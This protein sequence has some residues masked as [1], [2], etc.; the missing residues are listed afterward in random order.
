MVYLYLFY[1]FFMKNI[2]LLGNGGREHALANALSRS[3]QSIALF[4]FFSAKNPGIQELCA[5]VYIEKEKN[6]GA[7]S[8]FQSLKTFAEKN[9]IDFAVLGP[10]DPIGAGCADAL[11]E[12]GVPSFGPT[13][14]PAQLES[15]KGFTRSLL[16][17]YGIEGNPEFKRFSASEKESLAEYLTNLSYPFVIKDD[18]I[19]GGKGV[20]VHSDHFQTVEEGIEI[21]ERIL[22]KSSALVIEEKL[23]GPEFSLICIADGYTLIP[24]PLVA[25]HKRAYEG[26]TGPNT[27]GM[28]TISFADHLLPFVDESDKNK[29]LSIT[30]KVMEA[31]RE[32]TGKRFCGVL[33]GGFMKT[34]NGIKLIEYNTRFGDPEALNILPLLQTDAVALFESAIHATLDDLTV[35]FAPLC[36]VC[37]YLV[38]D[39]YPQNS[40]KHENINIDF[41]LLPDS[42]ELFYASVYQEEDELKLGGSRAVGIVGID[43]DFETASKKA[44]QG[45]SAVEGP[46]WARKDIGDWDLVQARIDLLTK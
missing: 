20:F 5:D 38:P 30:Q 12:V 25:D 26:D 9:R 42:T 40:V 17:E 8:G 16:E 4:G 1:H 44:N 2:L 11:L 29:A 24:C 33:Y 28:G 45:L 31:V 32:K 23:E 35:R 7:E 15:S 46:V 27:G 14:L 22:E 43:E 41:S 21:A 10:D 34:K 19:C 39:G 18:G 6:F 13:R 3:Y 36:T 37:K